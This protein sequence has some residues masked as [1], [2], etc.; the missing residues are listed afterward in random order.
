MGGK[1]RTRVFL[2]VVLL[3]TIFAVPVYGQAYPSKP[4]HLILPF[5]AGGLTDVLGRIIGQKYA[6][7]LG[8]PFISENKSGVGGNLGI[9]YAAK[10]RPDGYTIVLSS[11]LIAISPSLHK[12]M[13]YDPIKDLAPISLVAEIPNVL[14]VRLSLPVKTLRELVNYAKANPGKLN[15]GSGGIGTSQQI[16]AE[17]FKS[18]AEVDITHVAY[19]GVTPAMMAVIGNHIDMVVTGIP[20]SLQQILGGQ[21]RALAVLR[22]TRLESLPDVPTAKEAGIDLAT[23]TWYGL[24]APAGT[25]AEIISRLNAEWVKTST[26]AD[27]VEKMQKIGF[28]PMRNSPEEF[29]RFLKAETAR[30]AKV[31]KEAN[32][33]VE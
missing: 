3:S 25:P 1:I 22:D 4:V 12:K 26:T 9:E 29:S 32:L 31:I 11:P 33:T 7:S 2:I 17:L 28:E 6:E 23:T 5:Q 30:F 24:L 20:T 15:Y 18:L 21:I 19:K 10:A 8:Q 16:Y 27:T 14:C 13:N